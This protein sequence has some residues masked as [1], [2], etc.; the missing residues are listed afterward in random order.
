MSGD[1]LIIGEAPGATEASVGQPFRGQAGAVLRNAMKTIGIEGYI[2][3]AVKCRPPYNKK[4]GMTQ[5]RAC[6]HWLF[7]E[8]DV[9]TPAYVFT[10][11]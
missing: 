11:R 5:I 6:R 4:P 3:N 1:V 2:T 7:K 9:L 8:F 10:V